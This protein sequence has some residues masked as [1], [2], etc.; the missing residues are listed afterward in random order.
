KVSYFLGIEFSI[1][2]NILTMHQ[3]KYI[4][5]IL[6][7]LKMEDC[8]PQSTPGEKN[9]QYMGNCEPL[10]E[11]DL[12]SYNLKKILNRGKPYLCNDSY[13][14]RYMLHCDKVITIYEQYHMTMAKHALRF[15]K[16]SIDER[17]TFR[18]S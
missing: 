14:T 11:E 7:R 5:K 4:S 15:L 8:K 12:K 3:G 18:K 9:P 2:N 10:D 1:E 6:E 16:G 17:L 13:K